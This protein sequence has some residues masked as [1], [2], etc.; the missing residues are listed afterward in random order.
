MSVWRAWS[1]CDRCSFEYRRRDMRKESTGALVC[2]ACDDGAYDAKRHPQN[3]GPMPKREP[4]VVPDA[5]PPIELTGYLTDE[6]GN[7][8]L[9]EAGERIEIE[10]EVWT[11]RSSVYY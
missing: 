5:T 10:E 4:A 11:P 7:Y 9:T 6:D 2:R 3:K 1:V 8:I